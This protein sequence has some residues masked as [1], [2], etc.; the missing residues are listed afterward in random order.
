MNNFDLTKIIKYVPIIENNIENNILFYLD[1]EDVKD[2]IPSQ[3]IQTSNGLKVFEKK[4]KYEK[5]EICLESNLNVIYEEV[6][7]TYYEMDLENDKTSSSNIFEHNINDDTKKLMYKCLGCGSKIAM[8]SRRGP[9]NVIIVPNEDIKKILLFHTDVKVYVNPTNVHKDKIFIIR[10]D[11]DTSSPGLTLF[12][13]I[14]IKSSRHT[15][16]I[17]I[18][19]RMGKEI[20]DLD[21]KYCITKIGLKPNTFVRCIYLKEN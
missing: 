13:S 16:L 11:S 2:N 20:K 1:Y 6:L 17:K 8:E 10:V 19:K 7:N 18:L 4:L 21:F 12:T 15:K 3:F 14:D 9:S 5:I